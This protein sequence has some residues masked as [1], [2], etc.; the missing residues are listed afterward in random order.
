MQIYPPYP[1]SLT[2]AGALPL[3]ATA[4]AIVV[5]A[6]VAAAL[7]AG[8]LAAVFAAFFG[9]FMAYFAGQRFAAAAITSFCFRSA[10]AAVAAVVAPH[11]II[12]LCHDIIN[13]KW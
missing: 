1:P 7:A 6:G 12:S 8:F 13:I 5:A 10:G 4:P 3:F 2:E 9:G 11:F